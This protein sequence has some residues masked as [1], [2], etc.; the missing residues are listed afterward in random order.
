ME[1]YIYKDSYPC[2]VCGKEVKL[3]YSGDIN[4][5]NDENSRFK[6][7]ESQMWNDGTIFQAGCGYGSLLDG[8][9][10]LI[11]VCDDCLSKKGTKTGEYM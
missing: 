3:L 5:M 10:Y 7:P 4:V 6:N 8:S 2:I 1:K 11:A 9:I